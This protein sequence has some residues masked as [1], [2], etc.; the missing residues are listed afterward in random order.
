MALSATPSLSEIKTE[1]GNITL[2]S[3]TEFIDDVGQTG[4]WNSQLDF[5]LF[6][7]PALSITPTSYNFTSGGGTS[8]AF[9]ITSNT[10]WTISDNASWLTTSITTGIGNNTFTAT[11]NTN[12]SAAR[13]ATITIITGS[14]I[15]KTISIT[16]DGAI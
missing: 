9:S 7:L 12:L 1:V 3:L 16:Q 11:A 10:T 4:V 6:A 5:A 8:S 15:S 13:S 14:S 2:Y